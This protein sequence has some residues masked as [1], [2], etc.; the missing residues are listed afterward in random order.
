MLLFMVLSIL[1]VRLWTKMLSVELLADLYRVE[2]NTQ[3]VPCTVRYIQVNSEIAKTCAVI[4]FMVRLFVIA[5]EKDPA[6]FR[7]L[8]RDTTIIMLSTVILMIGTIAV[9]IG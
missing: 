9:I 1:A 3:N 4:L 6:W 7:C 8:L 5:V 2:N